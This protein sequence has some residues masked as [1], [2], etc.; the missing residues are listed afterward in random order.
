MKAGGYK[1]QT[2]LIKVFNDQHGT[3]QGSILWAEGKK[4]QYFRSALE[5][6][7]LMDDAIAKKNKK[8]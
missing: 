5:L 6:L 2:F 4:E 8:R 3:W 7:K 1:E